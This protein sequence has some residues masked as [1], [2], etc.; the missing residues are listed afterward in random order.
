MN[1][2]N[3]DIAYISTE[4]YGEQEYATYNNKYS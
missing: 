3:W 1:L 4:K 2:M